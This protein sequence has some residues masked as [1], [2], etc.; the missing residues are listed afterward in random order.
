MSLAWKAL[1]PLSVLNLFV[2]AIEV[3]IF[4]PGD[5]GLS[6]SELWIMTGVN[7]GI[8]II[9]IVAIFNL[10]GQRKLKRP[11]PVVSPLANMYANTNVAK[12]ATEIAEAD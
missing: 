10:A 8:T 6:T 9:A 3:F 2:I 1:L 4:N 5:G 11:D 7:W 12:K